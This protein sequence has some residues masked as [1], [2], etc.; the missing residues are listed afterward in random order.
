MTLESDPIRENNPAPDTQRETDNQT[1][2]SDPSILSTPPSISSPP[3]A[4]A[5]HE[6]ACK[7]KKDFW[8]TLKV[9]AEIVGIGLL[10]V[11]TGFT[12]LMYCANRQ[13]ANAAT[14][15]A[16]TASR[17]LEMMDR[18]WIKETVSP[19]ANLLAD[20]GAFSW[21][22][23]IKI[24]NVGHSVATNIY[25]RTELIAPKDADFIDGPR[26]RVI[27]LCE[28]ASQR[29]GNLKKDPL[30]WDTSIFPGDPVNSIQSPILFPNQEQPAIINGGEKLGKSV[31]LMLVGCI[32]YDYPTAS[33]FHETGFVYLLAHDD[34]VRIPGASRVF[35][36]V[37]KTVP[38]EKIKMIKQGQV[39]N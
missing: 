6:V 25:P 31:P 22:V 1:G 28:D 11:Y 20:K 16:N 33:K 4:K 37:E 26:K 39:A 27:E 32:A 12:I 10:A 38:K 9:R 21:A 15:A 8:D 3:P 17:Q 13:A 18:P 7:P 19:A 35:F 2:Q 23:T 14:S 36:S 24:D 34:D 30:L 5:H 29:A